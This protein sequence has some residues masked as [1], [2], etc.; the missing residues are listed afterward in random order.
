ML[1]PNHKDLEILA[2]G[3]SQFLQFKFKTVPKDSGV[4]L[5]LNQPNKYG[6]DFKKKL[7]WIGLNSYLFRLSCFRFAQEKNDGKIEIPVID[8]FI[9][10]ENTIWSGLGVIDIVAKAL[11]LPEK[12]QNDVRSWYERLVSYYKVIQVKDNIL[13]LENIIN[14][15]IYKVQLDTG[16]YYFNKDH[17]IFGGIV[18]YGDYYYW[19]GIQNDLGKVGIEKMQK[20]K[21]D[22]TSKA[23]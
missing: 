15:Q 22:F 20:I 14:E 11:D 10:Q 13:E 4:K 18:P 12:I 8:D 19:S 3:I 7:V 17:I 16:Q 2:E 9:C 5:F 6:W 23:N 21:N 1:S